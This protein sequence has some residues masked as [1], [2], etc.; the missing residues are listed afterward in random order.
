MRQHG[1]LAIAP[2]YPDITRR[3]LGGFARTA[4]GWMG[5]SYAPPPPPDADEDAPE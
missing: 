3:L 2:F 4:G 5:A 1:Y